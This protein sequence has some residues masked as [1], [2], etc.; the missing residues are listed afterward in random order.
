MRRI[1]EL[2]PLTAGRLMGLWRAAREAAEDPL[3]RTLLCHAGVLAACCFCRGEAVFGGAEA[4]LEELTGRQIEI[5]LRR[6]AEERP[7]KTEN[8]AF[9]Q[10]RFAALRED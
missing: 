5:L 9:D 2:R 3:E 10:E 8:P 4:V 1:D 6:L 7:S